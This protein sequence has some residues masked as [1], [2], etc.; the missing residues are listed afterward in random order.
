MDTMPICQSCGKPLAPNAP[1]GLCPEC[2]LKVGFPTEHQSDPAKPGASN[3][4]GFVPPTPAELAPH[5]AQLEI[6]Q[7]IG[8]G[9]MGAVYKA[10]Q[11]SLDRLVALKILPSHAASDTGFA[12]RF[13]REARALARLNH[14]NIVA[15]YEFGQTSGIPYFIMEYVEGRNLR[16]I[17]RSG[18]LLPHDALRI[19]QQICDALQFAHE[20]GVVHRDIKPENI[21]LDQKGRVKI[22]DFGIA[23]ILGQT[24]AGT[25]LTGVRD[26]VG[27]PSYMAPEQRESPQLVDHRADIFS[28]GVVF[29]ELL[30]G[31]LPVGK[32][33][34]PSQKAE[35]DVRVDDVVLRALEKE[36]ERRY[37]HV[38]DLETDV[39]KLSSAPASAPASLPPQTLPPV[40]TVPPQA[41]APDPTLTDKLILPA[42]LL[43]FFF[44]VFGAHRFYVGKIGTAIVQLFTL[45]GLGVWAV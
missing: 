34:P 22:A 37:Q 20:E 1:K 15:V 36:P 29:Y 10:R 27:T 30:T 43:A 16:E 31:E 21:L 18:G 40:H 26:V 5:F 38:V 9:G 3:P 44:G 19:V 32:F 12:E 28:L 39:A 25:S 35:V 11:P 41:A 14:S 24:E 2:L 6:Q 4:T 17:E 23:K 7:L 13:S 45:G 42:F 33:N 8:H